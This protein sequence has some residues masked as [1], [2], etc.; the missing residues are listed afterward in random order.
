METRRCHIIMPVKD[1][2]ETAEQAIRTIV[3][4]GYTLT[5]YN[6]YSTEEN[7]ARLHALSNE[8]GFEVI[9]IATL[10]EHPSPNYRY[11]LTDSRRKALDADAPLVI[12]E[13]D[14]IVAQDTIE[15]MLA[16]Q[17]SGTGMVAAV[18]HNEAG[19]V[20]FPYDYARK[21]ATVPMKTKKRF[22][23]C[24]TL[25]TPDLLRAMDWEKLLDPDKNWYDIT[26]SH[27]SVRL[28][29]DNVLLMDTPVLHKPH[30]SRPWKQLKYTHPLRYYWRKLTQ[31]IDKI[32]I[33]L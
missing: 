31:H 24:C 3:N 25:L 12:I 32:W 9:D 22:S 7:T 28:G 16:A 17:Q 29:F 5:V 20:N 6:D 4:S 8:M 11:V 19:E 26:I 21:W 14:V 15:H 13:S 2:L 33:R 18:T 1:S 10:L 23:F 27:E 30:S